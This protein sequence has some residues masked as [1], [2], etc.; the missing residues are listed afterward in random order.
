MEHLSP[1]RPMTWRADAEKVSVPQAWYPP[2]VPYA[3]R[4]RED[5]GPA[6]DEKKESGYCCTEQERD[7]PVSF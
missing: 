2:W 4:P 3:D 5:V 1:T 6:K 7:D